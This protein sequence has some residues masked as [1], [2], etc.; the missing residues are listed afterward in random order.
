MPLPRPTSYGLGPGGITPAVNDLGLG[1][2]L[3]DQAA[4]ETEEQRKKRLQQ[5]QSLGGGMTPATSALFGG[6]N[7]LGR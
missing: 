2:M 7:G 6:L 3:S 5:M 4:N 1:S